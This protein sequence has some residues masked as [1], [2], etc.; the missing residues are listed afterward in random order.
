LLPGLERLRAALDAKA[1]AFA[2][3]VKVGRT[4]AQDAT[5][6]TLGQEFSGYTAQVALGIERVKGALPRLYALAQGGTAVGTG[7]N[8][9]EGFDAAFARE[10]AALTGLPFVPAANKFEAMA[11]HDALVELSGVLNVLAVSLMKI[12]NDIRF[13]GS[14]PRAGLGELRLPE[15]EPGS[16]IMPGKVNP[17]QAEAVTMVATRVMGNHVTVTIAG[18]QGNFE[19]NVYK[20]V[21]ADALLQSIRLLADAAVSFAEN[22]IE[23]LQ[24]DEGRIRDLLEHSLMLV[25]ALSPHIGYDAA[26]RIAKKAHAEGT[27][28][29]EAA[30]ALGLVSA[31][32]FDRWVRPEDML[33]P[34]PR[35]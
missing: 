9:P 22:C 18:S 33:K 4:H 6:L 1:R 35:R 11:A 12:A 8:A 7:L 19:L 14:G 16:S 27:S 10:I 29:K 32:D 15:N 17:T 26:A 2:A 13:L 5:P 20:P 3:I 28:L 30:L 25:T 34:T 21:I 24:A 31:A 23:G